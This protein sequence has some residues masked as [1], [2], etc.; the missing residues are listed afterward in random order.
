MRILIVEDEPEVADLVRE[1]LEDEGYAVDVA[2]DGEVALELT[3]SF[4]YDLV[5]LDVML[6]ER[7][8][9]DV[10][11][12]LRSERRAVPILMLTA[13]DAVADRVAGLGTGADDYLVK[14]FHL[15]ELRA[16]VLALLRRAG[17]QPGNEMVVGRARIDLMAKRAWFG[18]R[19]IRLAAREYAVLEYLAFTP[20]ATT[21]A[22]SCS[23][24]SGR[25]PPPSTPGPSTPTSTTS[26]RSSPTTASTPSAASATASSDDAPPAPRPGI[27]RPRCR[28]ARSQRCRPPPAAPRQPAPR[29]RR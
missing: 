25:E 14:P 29:P 19:E 11:R 10:T 22:R 18:G 9:F 17:G 28:R 26:A 27:H 12:T 24:T 15:D 5:V 23:S 2:E 13:R 21:P 4:P 3:R 8:G 1:T 20:R 6:P 16:R 7:D